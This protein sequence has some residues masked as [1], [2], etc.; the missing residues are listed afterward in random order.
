MEKSLD[1]NSFR[2]IEIAMV[3]AFQGREKDIIIISC[4]RSHGTTGLGSLGYKERFHL[5]L[6]RAKFGLV[7]V[8]N[9]KALVKVSKIF[10]NPSV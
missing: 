6:T 2:A 5:V 10:I 7:I 8:G 1:T 3:D 4:V 9:S